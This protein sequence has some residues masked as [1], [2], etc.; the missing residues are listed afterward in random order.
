MPVDI[1]SGVVRLDYE[2]IAVP[3]KVTLLWERRYSTALLNEPATALGRGW[4]CRYF[5][6]LTKTAEGYQFQTPDGAIEIFPDPDNQVEQGEVIRNFGA[7]LEVF[8]TR[9][10]YI[11]QNWDVETGEIIRYCFLPG[12]SETAWLLDSIEDE[13]GQGLDLHWDTQKRLLSI[14]Q[15]LEQRTLLIGYSPDGYIDTIKMCASSGQQFQLCRYDYNSIGQQIASF[16]AAGSADYYDYDEFHRLNRER[17]KDGGVFTY[18]YDDQGRCFHTTGLDHYQE[19]QLRF[20]DAINFTEVTDSYGNTYRYQYL[21]T[22]QIIREIDPLGNESTTNY[23]E[24]GRIVAKTDA[25][26]ATTHYRYDNY[27]NRNSIADALNNTYQFTYNE[28]HLPQTI[29]DPLSHTWQRRYDS[30][31]RLISS[32][33]P[34]DNRWNMQYDNDGNIIEIT[35]P[36]GACKRLHYMQGTLQATTDWQGNRTLFRLDPFGRVIKRQG[37][38]GEITQLRYDVM[39]NPVAVNL[40]DGTTLQASYDNMSNMSSFSDGNGHTTHFHYGPCQRLLTR[41]DPLGGTVKFIWGSEP[42]YLEKI[43]NEKKETYIFYRDAAGRVIREKSFDGAERYFQYNKEGY[44]NFYINANNETIKIQRDSLHRIIGQTLPDGEQ[45]SYGFDS[46]G[47]LISAVNNDISIK[48]ERDELGRIIKEFQGNEWV[49]SRYDTIGNLIQ[50]STS[51]GHK[52]DYEFDKN[53][54]MTKLIT[55]EKQSLKFQRDANGKEVYRQMPG[56]IAME[57]CYDEL[58]RLIKQNIQPDDSKSRKNLPASSQFSIIKRQYSYNKNGT[59]NS[60]IDN[61]SGRIDYTYDPAERLIQTIYEK[62]LIETFSYDASGNITNRKQQNKD[63]SE[64]ENLIYEKGNRLI[65]KNNIIY[66]YDLE[67]RLIKK[68]ESH[69]TKNQKIWLYKWNAL[70]KLKEVKNPNGDTWQYKYDAF[71]RRV[72]KNLSSKANTRQKFLW[73]K[74]SLIHEYNPIDD[75]LSVWIFDSDSF[76]PLATIQKNSLYT[77]INDHLGTPKELIDSKGSIALSIKLKSWGDL[78]DDS[79]ISSAHIYCPVRFQ[80]QWMDAE[81]LLHYNYNRY[82][83]PSN[84][85][86]ISQDPIGLLGD[87]NLYRYVPNPTGW[88]DPLGCAYDISANTAG[89]DTL[90][91]GAHVN[92]RGPGLPR[93]GG[94]V[95]L[96]PNSGG[97]GLTPVPVDAATRDLKNKQWRNLSNDVTGFFDDQKNVQRLRSQAQAGIDAYPKSARARELE[98]VRDI[99]D[100]HIKKGTNPC[101]G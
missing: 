68:V 18:R 83:D 92:A 89:P 96:V 65:Q 26:G 55:L 91:R 4:T 14:Q 45:I 70:G 64:D 1:A 57:Q 48:F 46:I 53:G 66:E 61:H 81:T 86:Y 35:N 11:V 71:G 56:N 24:Y 2:D 33:D 74:D 43:I 85:R 40:P 78:F 51:L 17:V 8:K 7:F 84:G 16:D 21:E 23:D 69:D 31:N 90:A 10:H 62:A 38:L 88:V 95:G 87:Y 75:T 98:K 41:T 50:T 76:T 22:G 72:E 82:Y 12:P 28:L 73:D 77:I 37:P 32:I 54:L 15:R 59:L 30:N 27:G 20:Y 101:R 5:A 58:G 93:R 99:C 29:T 63:S 34:L 36:L 60:M 100:E 94:H 44:A 25:T 49:E 3:G 9:Q 13:T 80:G 67:G 97:D 42:D 79:S 19:K 47:N 52:A 6:T 39:G